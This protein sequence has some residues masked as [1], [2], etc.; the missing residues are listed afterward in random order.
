MIKYILC[1]IPNSVYGG[2]LVK[3]YRAWD[4]LYTRKWNQQN[5]VSD[6]LLCKWNSFP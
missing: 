3:F 5:D 6:F 2:K 1:N 4:T